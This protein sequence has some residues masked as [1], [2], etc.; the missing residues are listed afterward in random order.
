LR[1][2]WANIVRAV[3]IVFSCIRLFAVII[4]W[5]RTPKYNSFDYR[6]KV[7]HIKCVIPGVI[8]GFKIH[9]NKNHNFGNSSFYGY[10]YFSEN[11][12]TWE[13]LV[14]DLNQMK[15]GNVLWPYTHMLQTRTYCDWN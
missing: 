13:L 11:E 5:N 2:P 8:I 3:Q 15:G 14:V 10:R 1:L 9:L 7:I 6:K 12:K 4:S